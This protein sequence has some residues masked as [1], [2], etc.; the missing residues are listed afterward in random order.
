M[1]SGEAPLGPD[2]ERINLHHTIQTEDSSVA[3]L[4][5]TMHEENRR[6]LHVNWPPQDF[7][8]GVNR[9]EFTAW[10]KRYWQRRHVD[11]PEG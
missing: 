11:F 6:A 9:R 7:P 10:R 2:G 4:T 1:A 5:R 8:S 3:E